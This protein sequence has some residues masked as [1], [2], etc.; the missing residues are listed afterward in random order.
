MQG[1]DWQSAC[2]AEVF[3]PFFVCVVV[4]VFFCWCCHQ[5][6]LTPVK[7]VLPEFRPGGNIDCTK[8]TGQILCHVSYRF[9]KLWKPIGPLDLYRTIIQKWLN[10]WKKKSLEASLNSCYFNLAHANPWCKQML[11]YSFWSNMSHNRPFQAILI[12][13]RREGG[14]LYLPSWPSDRKTGDCC[15]LL[16]WATLVAWGLQANPE[17]MLS[18][19]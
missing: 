5:Y 3:I 11:P 2:G 12:R 8:G 14:L 9:Q 13:S 18:I 6:S 15:G 19:K 16:R 10:G 7:N 1:S 17:L 4:V